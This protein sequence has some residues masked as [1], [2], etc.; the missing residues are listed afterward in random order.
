MKPKRASIPQRM[1]INQPSTLQT[2]HALHGKHVLAVR[3][4]G[5]TYRV[6][7]LAG[8]TVSQQV[9]GLALSIGWPSACTCSAIERA[10]STPR[11]GCP[12]HWAG[13]ADAPAGQQIMKPKHASAHRTNARATLQNLNIALGQDFHTLR[14]SQTDALL[15]EADR[16]KYRKPANANGSRARY[17]HDLLQRRAKEAS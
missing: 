1:W 3:E 2:H 6:Y 4:Y 17:F 12:E 11:R 13:S 14:S 10:T 5:D 15:Q 9:S 16:V 7:F 8:Q